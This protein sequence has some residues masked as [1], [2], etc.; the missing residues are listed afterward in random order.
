LKSVGMETTTT[1]SWLEKEKK[2]GKPRTERAPRSRTPTKKITGSQPK[3]RKTSSQPR[4]GV[5]EEGPVDLAWG[6]SLPWSSSCRQPPWS[7]LTPDSDKKENGEK[8]KA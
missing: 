7:P 5:G 8:R 2:R 6:S 3:Y 1:T 4:S